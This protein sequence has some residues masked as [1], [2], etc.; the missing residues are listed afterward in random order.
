MN[1]WISE[2]TYDGILWTY[3]S[4]WLL[5][6]CSS[7]SYKNVP[8]TATISWHVVLPHLS[9]NHSRFHPTEVSGKYQQ[10][11]LVAKQG[12]TWREMSVNF[13]GELTLSYSVGFFFWHAV[14]SP[15]PDLNPRTL[16]PKASVVTT[17]PPRMTYYD[18][19]LSAKRQL[20]GLELFS[21]QKDV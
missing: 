4:Y 13:A 5:L 3:D 17:I 21:G 9:Y 16:D 6:Q 2:K 11:H 1:E 18:S 7:L 14:K 15:R 12:E 20:D 8:F 19:W 10:R